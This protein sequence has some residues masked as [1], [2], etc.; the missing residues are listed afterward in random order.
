MMLLEYGDDMIAIDAGLM[1]PQEEMLG[2]DLVI[3]DVTYIEQHR[4]KLRAIFITH[5]HE[6]HIGAPA[7]LPAQSSARRSTA[8][9]SPTA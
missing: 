2:V 8:R 3:P 9:R 4:E 5:G 7:V 1:F 6:D